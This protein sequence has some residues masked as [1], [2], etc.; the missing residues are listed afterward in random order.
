MHLLSALA[1]GIP[2]AAGGYAS[3]HA[4]GTSQAASYYSTFEGE[5]HLTSGDDLEL[6]SE[7]SAI[8]YVNE[9]VDVYVYDATGTLVRQFTDGV[10]ANVVEYKGQSFTGTDYDTLAQAAGNPIT[11]EAVL[12]KWFDQ[13]GDVDFK[14]K[15]GSTTKALPSWLGA[16]EGLLFNVKDPT[17]GAVGDGTT[18]DG[19]AIASAVAAAVAAGG[20]TVFFP[21]GTYRVTSAVTVSASVN[22]LGLG[23][24][25]SVLTIDHANEN[26]LGVSASTYYHTRISGLRLT[27]AQTNTGQ[28]IAVNSIAKPIV[29]NCY[30]G[31]ANCTGNALVEAAAAAN[32]AV[33]ENCTF[34][35]GGAAGAAIDCSSTTGRWKVRR[36]RFIT[37]VSCTPTNDGI[38]YGTKIDLVDCEF[39][40]TATTTG[41]LSCFTASSTTLDGEMRGNYISASGG[42]TLK[43]Y[44]LGTPIAGSKFFE[45]ETRCP[46][47]TISTFTLYSYTATGW[48]SGTI[49]D[50][51]QI[52]LRT[53]ESRR[54]TY[55]NDDEDL[56][57]DWKNYGRIDWHKTGTTAI[58]LISTTFFPLEGTRA[59]LTVW[60]DGG[61]IGSVAGAFG[62]ASSSLTDTQYN[63]WLIEAQ[64]YDDAGN[65]EARVAVISELFDHNT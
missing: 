31:G 43:G 36:C 5:S 39:D 53:R 27:A 58:T 15:V 17:Y 13:S 59:R 4:R 41:T 16:L 18:D 45:S 26:L 9:L 35:V 30:I 50:N 19:S 49:P 8:A 3:I 56:N 11:V 65:K 1:A 10:T 42:A 33:I 32:Y 38:V 20:G 52:D 46:G 6:D 2:S 54:I 23:P 34:N 44:S 57:F 37:P 24:N 28:M 14:V 25:A 60:A 47:Y 64:R 51:M 40:I 48:T 22:L 63:T 21:P 55:E 61:A 29:E 12:N 62:G 7:G